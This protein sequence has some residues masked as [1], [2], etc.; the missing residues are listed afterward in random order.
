MGSVTFTVDW[1]SAHIP[2]W[3]EKV[4]PKI[5]AIE[6]PTYLEIGSHEGRSL[7]WMLD[8]VLNLYATSID[9]HEDGSWE[10]FES[11]VGDHARII[12]QFSAIEL[13]ILL[14]NQELYDIIYIDGSHYAY[15]VFFDSALSWKLL[16]SS[17]ILIW[18]DY[19]W[20]VGD[21]PIKGP[22]AA[23]DAFLICY[24][25]QYKVLHIGY[26]FMVEKL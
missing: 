11:N 8:N 25:T 5:K 18:D 20:L 1:F 4:L 14:K 7:L 12:R 24:R 26:Q 21:D 23:I 9:P 15:D 3:E 19:G 17:G 16:K 22:K 2:I 10:N 13:P 6:R